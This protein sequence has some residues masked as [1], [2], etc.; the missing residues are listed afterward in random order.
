MQKL[1]SILIV[2]V[3]VLP[4]AM[5]YNFLLWKID[6]E[7][8][9]DIKISE[10]DPNKFNKVVP[11][12]VFPGET[13]K[14]SLTC[15]NVNFDGDETAVADWNLGDLSPSDSS[16]EVD[17]IEKEGQRS[18][19]WSKEILITEEDKGD[20]VYTYDI[21][22]GNSNNL[23]YLRLFLVNIPMEK[24]TILLLLLNSKCMSR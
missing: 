18:A 11:V 6:D 13:V 14:L 10:S 5:G 3:T 17:I 7:Y 16:N 24:Q 21:N 19:S 4:S 22:F 20:Q 15:V 12:V 9:T 8:A 2:I 1:I 23:T